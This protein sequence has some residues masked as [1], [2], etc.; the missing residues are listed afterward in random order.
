[1]VR[2]SFSFFSHPQIKTLGEEQNDWVQGKYSFG[3]PKCEAL[4]M[5]LSSISSSSQG[6][7]PA[8]AAACICLNHEPLG[9]R[10]GAC[11]YF[12]KAIASAEIRGGPIITVI[13]RPGRA[14]GPCSR[15]HFASA[16]NPWCRCTAAAIR[17][18]DERSRQ[19][20]F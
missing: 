4:L 1:M 14:Q 11:T 15:C 17:R 18:G 8:A 16:C 2:G 6:R 7:Q 19:R 12:G 9:R 13:S 20:E 5:L 10:G 3:S